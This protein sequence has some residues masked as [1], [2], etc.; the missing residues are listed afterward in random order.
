[1]IGKDPTYAV[2]ENGN[3]LNDEPYGVIHRIAS[4]GRCTIITQNVES[5]MQMMPLQGLLIKNA[6]TIS[7][8]CI[9][10]ALSI[11]HPGVFINL[12]KRFRISEYGF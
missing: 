6:A 4:N 12:T 8:C 5:F 3:W 2:I 1:M 9:L 11:I 7:D 10:L